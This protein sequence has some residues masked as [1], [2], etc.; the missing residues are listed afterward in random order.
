MENHQPTN[1]ADYVVEGCRA[2][3]PALALGRRTAC[4]SDDP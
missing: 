4:G 1:G 2:H 3:R